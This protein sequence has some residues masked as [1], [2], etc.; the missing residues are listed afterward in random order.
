ME[1]LPE[2]QRYFDYHH[3]AD[4]VFENVHR[5][6]LCLGT[7]AMSAMVYMLSQYGM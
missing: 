4:D 6:E 1:L 3:S 5:R 2:S 7:V